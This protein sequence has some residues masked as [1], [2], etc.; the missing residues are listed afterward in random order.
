MVSWHVSV[1]LIHKAIEKVASMELIFNPSRVSTYA[2][3]ES[4]DASCLMM[5]HQ[6][7]FIWA[8]RDAWRI[9]NTLYFSL[10]LIPLLTDLYVSLRLESVT[11]AVVYLITQIS[12]T[13]VVVAAARKIT[14]FRL[15]P[16][17]TSYH[18]PLHCC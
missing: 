9:F 2:Y 5:Y 14:R 16:N 18:H 17:N 8:A 13:G 12:T 10:P 7:H 3:Q 6:H 11:E 15:R 1:K 4:K